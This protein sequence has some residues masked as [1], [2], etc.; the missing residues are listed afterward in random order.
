MNI[1]FEFFFKKKK[2]FLSLFLMND[3]THTH[4]KWLIHVFSLFTFAFFYHFCRILLNFLRYK[5]C[6]F[7]YFLKSFYEKG[8]HKEIDSNRKSWVFIWYEWLMWPCLMNPTQ[9]GKFFFVFIRKD[10]CNIFGNVFLFF[11][12]MKIFFFFTPFTLFIESKCVCVCVWASHLYMG[13]KSRFSSFSTFDP[14]W[15]FF[16]LFWLTLFI[17]S[18]NHHRSS[19]SNDII[20]RVFSANF[21]FL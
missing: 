8:S 5:C 2:I 1:F 14:I 17:I 3:D 21:F 6:L 19:L 18:H 13:H 10:N 12:K 4:I 11:S 15:F 20:I 16:V 7:I 9:N